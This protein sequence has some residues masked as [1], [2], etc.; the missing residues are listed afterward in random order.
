MM[1]VNRLNEEIVPMDKKINVIKDFIEFVNDKLNLK[2]NLP[3]ISL[4][5][6][7]DEAK[8]MKSFGKYV[9]QNN[10]IKVIIANR[11]LGDIL[12]TIAHELVHHKQKIENK[13]TPESGRTGS[14]HEN[15]ANAV[16]GALLREFGQRNSIIYEQTMK[17]RKIK[18]DKKRL[19]EM[20]QKVNKIT[21]DESMVLNSYNRKLLEEKFEEL[22]NK[23][24]E[25]KHVSSN[26]VD[27]VFYVELICLDNNK[28]SVIF[29]FKVIVTETEQ[30]NIYTIESSKLIGFKLLSDNYGVAF[31]EDMLSEFNAQHVSDLIDVV[32]E[33]INIPSKMEIELDE[34]AMSAI[35]RIDAIPYKKGTESM[36]KN[37]QYANEK[38]TN[39]DLRAGDEYNKFVSEIEDG[40]NL[41]DEYPGNEVKKLA[42]EKEKRGEIIKG[43]LGDNKSPLEFN[44]KQILMGMKV[45]MEHTDDPMIAL[46]ITLDHLSEDPEYYTVKDNPEASAQYNAAKDANKNEEDEDKEMTDMLLGYK[47]KNV[48]DSI[49]ESI[50]S[51]LK[52]KNPAEWHRVQ[53][54][55][56]TLRMPNAILGVMGGMTKEEARDVLNQYGIK[57]EE[58][59]N[60]EDEVKNAYQRYLNYQNK[61]FNSMSDDEKRD[62]FEIWN[63]FKSMKK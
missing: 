46:E 26:M 47:S 57:Y 56:K 29:K 5:Q 18:D 62:Y 42:K 49:D 48:G 35:Q 30:D 28:D 22:K 12:R 15:E 43:G 11:N 24:L 44:P 2:G 34:K 58:T 14:E 9:P 23:K 59:I 37:S 8:E 27:D 55:K 16:A 40:V 39:P 19:I 61:D 10:E 6:N 25:I 51:E 17:N 7:P 60:E 1:K 53:I 45:E 21:L 31:N 63:K 13:L 41:N 36:I 33:Y 32:Y 54:A 4:S 52:K 50:E 3:N 38:P 20:F